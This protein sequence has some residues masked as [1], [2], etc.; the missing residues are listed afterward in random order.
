MSDPTVGS[1][2]PLNIPKI[3]LGA[4]FLLGYYRRYFLAAFPVVLVLVLGLDWFES[5][6]E[7][8]VSG[9]PRF[10]L[11]IGAMVV[12]ASLIAIPC[13]KIFLGRVG[14]VKGALFPY[15]PS[16]W[17][18]LAYSALFHVALVL[19]GFIWSYF[20]SGSLL[21]TPVLLILLLYLLS[22]F[23]LVLP[24]SAVG[25]GIGL[26]ESWQ[27][28]AGNGWRLA[29]L[30]FGL[31]FL[32]TVLLSPFVAAALPTVVEIIFGLFMIALLVVQIGVLS[33]AYD[34]L[35]RGTKTPNSLTA[36]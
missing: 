9:I 33:L 1:T 21:L 7:G 3:I 11:G 19:P 18:F 30:L 23:M 31:P 28:T 32:I 29:L 27:R 2:R 13:H 26:K 4:I 12:W 22:R 15:K 5:G 36:P 35:G 25:E 34:E 20:F 8:R 14:S 10:M 24:A 6:V 17:L 16:H